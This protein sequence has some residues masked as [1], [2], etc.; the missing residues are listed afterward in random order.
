ME[1]IFAVIEEQSTPTFDLDGNV[2][3][4]YNIVCYLIYFMSYTNTLFRVDQIN[5][6]CVIEDEDLRRRR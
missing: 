6:I 1:A 5:N 3:S 4:F 2:I